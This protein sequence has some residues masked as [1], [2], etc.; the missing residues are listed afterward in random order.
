VTDDIPDRVIV[1]ADEAYM[2]A[3][4]DGRPF[5]KMRA[6]ARVI[7]EHVRAEERAAV[8]RWLLN[9][10]DEAEWVREIVASIEAGEHVK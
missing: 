10:D 8:V 3:R 2:L 7:A 4:G 5:P 9:I 6:A 1:K